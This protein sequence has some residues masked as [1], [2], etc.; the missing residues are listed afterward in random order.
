MGAVAKNGVYGK[1]RE[2][3]LT[4]YWRHEFGNIKNHILSIKYINKEIERERKKKCLDGV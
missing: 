4:L 3:D 1:G 2:E